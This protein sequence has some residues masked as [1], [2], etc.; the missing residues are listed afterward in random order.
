MINFDLCFFVVL[1]VGLRSFVLL[2]NC[3]RGFADALHH[4]GQYGNPDCNNHLDISLRGRR[5][6]CICQLSHAW[7]PMLG[8]GIRYGEALHPG[9]VDQDE[10]C[11]IRFCITN[12]TCLSNKQDVY[13]EL[14][15]KEKFHFVSCSETAATKST[16]ISFGSSLRKIGVSSFWGLPVLPQQSTITAK[17]HARG[18][19]SGVGV[20]TKLPTRLC[21]NPWPTE[22]Q[23]CDRLVHVICQIGQSHIQILVLYCK[24]TSTAKNVDFNQEL[25]NFAVSESEKLPLPFIIMGDFNMPVNAFHVWDRLFLK[26]CRDLCELYRDRYHEKIPPTCTGATNP[27]NAILSSTCV[28]LL[29]RI[30]VLQDIDLATHKPVSF[31]LLVPKRGLFKENFVLPKQFV[32][33]ALDKEDFSQGSTINRH[34]TPPTSLE[35]WGKN[36][37]QDI[38]SFLR[39]EKNEYYPHFL[40][41]GFR[42]RCQPRKL[43]KSLIFAPIKKASDGD[44][45]PEFEVISMKTRKQVTQLRR[46]Q[47]LHQR[48]RKLEQFG[49][50]DNQTIPGIRQEWSVIVK[51]TSFGSSFL[52][53]ICNQ[54]EVH[55][56]DWPLPTAEWI[57]D[58]LQIVK[59]HVQAKLAADMKIHTSK[60]AYQQRLDKRDNHSKDAFR[61]VKGT[62]RPPIKELQERVEDRV[63]VHV[64]NANQVE[65]F[66]S[67]IPKLSRNFPVKLNGHIATVDAIEQDCAVLSFESIRWDVNEEEADLLQLKYWIHPHDLAKLLN[68]F[69]QPIWLRDPAPLDLWQE[70][71]AVENLADVFPPRPIP[72]DNSQD[73]QSWKTAIHRLKASAARGI[74]GVSAQ[75]LKFLDNRQL[76]DLMLV[77]NDY[78]NGFPDW[79]MI[80]LVVPLAKTDGTPLNHQSRPVTILS[81]LYRVWAAVL[82]GGIISSF[83]AWMPND[84]TGFLP[85]RGSAQVAYMMQFSIERAH[86]FQRG[87]SGLTLDLQKCFNTVKWLFAL[88]TLSLLRIPVALLWK[89]I[90]SI[91]RLQ[92]FWLLGGFA[93]PAGNATT[94]FPEG[95][96]WSVVM[97]LGMACYW[98]CLVR[99]NIRQRCFLSLSAYAD[100]WAWVTDLPICHSWAMDATTQIT[101]QAGVK[102]DWTKTWFW[103]TSNSDSR[104][105]TDL[106]QPFSQGHQISRKTSTCDLGFQ[107]QY[108]GGAKL[109]KIVDRIEE[110]ERRIRRLAFMPQPLEVKEHLVIASIFPAIFYGS[111]IRP[112]SC[113]KLEGVRSKVATS[114]FGDGRNLSAPLA[115]LCTGNHILDPFFHLILKAILIARQFLL[116]TSQEI[117]SDFCAL[118][119]AFRGSLSQV[120]GPASALAHY[121]SQLGWQITSTGIVHMSAFL[122]FPLHKISIGRIRRF[123]I[124][125][126]QEKLVL[127]HTHRHSLRNFPDISR[128]DTCAVLRNWEAHDRQLLIREI[129]GGFQDG[130]QKQKWIQDHDGTCKFC[131]EIDAKTHRLL[132]CSLGSEERSNF[133]ELTKQLLDSESS[134]PELP[135]VHVSPFA[136]AHL[137]LQFRHSKPV[138]AQEFKDLVNNRQISGQ[139]LHWF[140]DGSCAYPSLAN[141]RFSSFA[142]VIDICHNDEQRIA[143]AESY[144]HLN[145][146]PPCFV[147]AMTGRT[148]GEQDIYRAELQAVAAVVQEARYGTVHCD[149]QVAVSNTSHLKNCANTTSLANSEHFDVLLEM[150]ETNSLDAIQIQKI[151]AHRN[152]SQI[153]DPMERFLA[154][155]NKC[156]DKAAEQ[157]CAFLHHDIVQHYDKQAKDILNERKM[158]HDAL[159]LNLLLQKVRTQAQKDTV[160]EDKTTQLTGDKI[161]DA[162][163]NWQ[164]DESLEWAPQFDTSYLRFSTYGEDIALK[165]LTWFSNFTWPT[166]VLG[167]TGRNTGVS[168]VELGLSWVLF[169]KQYLPI[170]RLSSSGEMRI[171]I[172]GSDYDANHFHMTLSELGASVFAVIRNVAALTPQ[173]V[174]PDQTTVKCGSLYL[175]GHSGY[176]MGWSK[177]PIFPAQKD[178]AQILR[179]GF[180][181]ETNNKLEWLPIF[182]IVGDNVFLANSAAERAR[183]AN[184]QMKMVRKI[185]LNL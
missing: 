144:Q 162:F 145:E 82:C 38:D 126:W 160:V 60:L 44:F 164:F 33:L 136:D 174:F 70:W 155:G 10:T 87:I 158:L 32:E 152:I 154:M 50:K 125:A 86:R 19:A 88:R 64:L 66:G 105:I 111:E 6:S 135:V 1:P 97:M 99:A 130:L 179:N 112:I 117:F 150:W 133:P 29:Q 120:K 46:I 101:E 128:V 115:L 9:P 127:M 139:I 100:N 146:I 12:P 3:D 148:I 72:K 124:M 102:I 41:R 36:L 76:T 56:P 107:M 15:K 75:E 175:Q 30:D 17:E 167:P 48:I 172:P 81:Q 42:G 71:T 90:S 173:Q 28:P 4:R 7:R 122:S 114:L 116:T 140:T 161:L 149:S 58:I 11:Q 182:G 170:S 83:A 49:P 85:G 106:L 183:V 165:T 184:V 77:M 171:V 98:T 142:V 59:F 31:T 52:H 118:A 54:P 168:W 68:D 5:C 79:F 121:I 43:V 181:D 27:D 22:W 132:T 35:D 34:R 134:I 147:V 94:G 159:E 67:Q 131:G 178:V 157:S 166:G 108:S 143:F 151:K 65:V 93:I 63:I 129:A 23:L 16:Q 55:P 45:E 185:R 176:T 2:I 163:A 91:Q 123:A 104:Q 18:K 73:L 62:N 21:R 78:P 53:W 80:G 103:S 69:W 61:Q 26:G 20:L 177:R 109:G 141:G 37:E 51:N 156:A 47:S 89:W 180:L 13:R 8:M 39:S 138:L 24:P 25:M 84:V 92:R 113:Q 14:F 96:V 119:S 137:T 110:G 57:F 95:D 40:P 169:H 74:D 153:A